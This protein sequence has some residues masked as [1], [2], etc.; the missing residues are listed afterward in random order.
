[1]SEERDMR[2]KTIT[3][4]ALAIKRSREVGKALARFIEAVEKMAQ[5][6]ERDAAQSRHEVIVGFDGVGTDRN[7]RGAKPLDDG[8]VVSEH[9]DFA[10]A[11]WSA[12]LCVK[13][14]NKFPAGPEIT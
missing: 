8:I 3:L 5:E 6:R 2:M 4:S 14:E 12:V 10:G 13:S 1:M 7:Y 11:E 9:C